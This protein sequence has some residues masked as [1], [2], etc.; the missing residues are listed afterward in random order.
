MD[1]ISNDDLGELFG[2]AGPLARCLDGFA[3]RPEQLAMAQD[4]Q[5]AIRSGR[6]LVVE[7]GTGTGKTLAYLVPALLSGHRI[8]ISTGTKTLQDQLFH[9]DLPT[10]GRALGRPLEVRL[11]KGRA[12]YLCRYR[13]E[14]S[15]DGLGEAG[16]GSVARELAP[17][18]RWADRTRT[19]DISEMTEIGE[20]SP[21]WPR[22][23]S[24]VDNCLGSRCP[25]FDDCHVFAA[26][27]A[28]RDADLVVVNHHLLMADLTMK[29]EGFGELLPGADAV[30][31]DEAHQFP[32]VAQGFFD[33]GVSSGQVRDLAGDLRAE[34]LRAGLF[35]ADLDRLLDGVQHAG[36][37]AR[38]ALPRT[39]GNIAWA[40][41]G[42]EFA[43]ALTALG[44]VF[45]DL[46]ARLGDVDPGHAGLARCAE[47]SA[48]MVAALGDIGEA[49]EGAALRWVRCGGRFFAA[50]VTP[51]DASSEIRGL[52]E[53]RPCTWIFTSATLAVRDDFRHFTSRIGIAGDDIASRQIASPFDY[54]A[55]ARLYLP[56]GLPNPNS[57]DYTDRSV[58]A[59]RAAVGA[60]R[61][62]AFLLF[63]SHRAL[64]R[65]AEILSGETDFDFPLLVQGQMPRTRLL[66]RFARLERAVLL[67]TA[68]FWEGVDIRGHQ[69]V[70][71]AI[72]R[73][74]F[75]S[76]GDP[77]LAA[78]LESIRSH[79][80][81]PFR[82]Y[83]LPEAVLS[84]KQGVGRLIRDYDD[85]GVVMICDPR[86]RE[87]SY[88]RDFLASLPAMR[89]CGHSRFLC[90]SGGHGMIEPCF[91]NPPADFRCLAIETSS[92]VG[93]IAACADGRLAQRSYGPPGP[94]SRQVYRYV[95]EVLSAT[96][97]GLEELDC[98]AFGQGPGGFTG[99]RVGAA[100]VQALAY[101]NGLPVCRVSSLSRRRASRSHS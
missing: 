39:E 19:G 79:G 16:A 81:N 34:A 70:L 9:R 14:S 75:A 48:A 57:K 17:L 40:D 41:A 68:T 46:C 90:G 38:A 71:V 53:A 21:V 94:E 80:G 83:Q 45:A 101:G 89:T 3:P 91:Q 30:I 23:T 28:A 5:C 20:D 61:G 95:R 98:I 76:P 18:Q 8:V 7:A 52:L 29:D 22:V 65:A 44:E 47:R 43:A 11:L 93:S 99:L 59:M 87:K 78:K 62:R 24:T 33:V 84:L 36:D 55:I 32:R 64:R 88:G 27:Q 56:T 42:P 13:L 2:V 73:L 63:T 35:D 66:E 51:L 4:V 15:R 77:M 50:H 12:N 58:A 26:R 10:I 37:D 72:D 69:L 54:P 82:D 1:D 86:V 60:S 85:F 74:P 67:G 25:R 100:V 92:A 49:D 6:N 97:V 96:D 31:V